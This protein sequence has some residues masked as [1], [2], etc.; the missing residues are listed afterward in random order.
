VRGLVFSV[1]L[2]ACP[3]YVLMGPERGSRGG[4]IGRGGQAGARILEQRLML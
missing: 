3:A 4:A 1:V 2:W